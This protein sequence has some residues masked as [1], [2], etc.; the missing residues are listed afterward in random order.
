ME[1]KEYLEKKLEPTSLPKEELRKYFE[2]FNQPFQEVVFEEAG[3][4]TI[5]KGD[6]KIDLQYEFP[7]KELFVKNTKD[8]FKLPREKQ[9]LFEG[10][11]AVPNKYRQLKKFT[12]ENKK[13]VL[14]ITDLVP[15][16]KIF[17]RTNFD[18]KG[19]ESL[20]NSR[21]DVEINSVILSN[22][23]LNSYGM[24]ILLHEVGHASDPFTLSAEE[25]P[26]PK[27]PDEKIYFTHEQ[28]QVVLRSERNA[29]AFMLK[30]IKPFM[31]DLEIDPA[32]LDKFIQYQ[33]GDY[34]RQIKAAL[35]GKS[36]PPDL[37][38]V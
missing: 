4:L 28:L 37:H 33:L 32:A 23:I 15:E 7:P 27:D 3:T 26:R 14:N 30:K 31:T 9:R 12:L 22:H 1:H 17:F 20:G 6:L 29:N 2:A 36:W 10:M 34:S 25:F 8:I 18:K 38:E 13:A 35:S 11:D 21:F 5:E 24:A 16:T 19:K